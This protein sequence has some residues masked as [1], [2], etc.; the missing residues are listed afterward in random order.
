MTARHMKPIDPAANADAVL[1][2]IERGRDAAEALSKL[3]TKFGAT[4]HA[5]DIL[6]ALDSHWD[7]VSVLSHTIHDAQSHIK[8]L[9]ELNRLCA[10]KGKK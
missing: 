2:H 5:D 3:L 10:Q 9:Q 7:T 4:I 1:A 6:K 8:R